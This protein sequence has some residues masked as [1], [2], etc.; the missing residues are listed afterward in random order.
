MSAI[1]GQMWTSPEFSLLE[2]GRG[3]SSR[4]R[5]SSKQTIQKA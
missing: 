2:T 4:F 1:D 5:H 3:A